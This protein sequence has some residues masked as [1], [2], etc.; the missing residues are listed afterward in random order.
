MGRRA[1]IPF[2]DLFDVTDRVASAL[3]QDIQD[4]IDRFA[5]VDHRARRSPGAVHHFGKLQS[6][7]EAVGT[8]TESIDIG[9]GTLALPLMHEGLPFQLSMARQAVAGNLEPAADA[10]QLNLFL[11]DFALTLDGLEPAIYVPEVGTTPRHLLRDPNNSTVRIIGSAVLRLQKTAGSSD[12]AAVFVDQPDPFDPGLPSGA[13]ARLT[14]SPPHFFLGSSDVGLTVRELEF[15]F[16]DDYSPPYVLEHNQGPSWVGLVIREATVYAPRNL[17]IVGD[18]SGGVRDLLIG[19]PMGIQGEFELQFGRTALDPATFIFRQEPDGA[20]RAVSGTGPA[21]TVDIAGGQD[22]STTIHAALN[23]PAPPDDG[24]LPTGA[25]QDWTARWIWPGQIPVEADTS[26]GT[27]RH[28]QTLTV[29]PVEIVTV[30]GEAT[31]FNHPPMTF[32][33]VA[34]GETPSMSA[35][36]G[37]ESF[38]NVVHLG[39]VAADIGAVTLAASSTAPGTSTFTWTIEAAQVE[40]TGASFSPRVDGLTGDHFVVLSED[41]DGED[42]A[43]ITRVRLRI[44]PDGELLVGCESGVFRSTDDTTPLDPAAVEATFDLSDFHA[45]GALNTKRE[46]AV[47]DPAA[48][49][50]VTVPADGLAQVTIATGDPSPPPEHDRHV[51]VLMRF[52]EDEVVGWGDHRPAQGRATANEADLQI[53]LLQWANNYPNAE[54]LA[55]GRCDDVGADVAGESPDTFNIGL[56]KDRAGKGRTLLTALGTG[57]TGDLIG[58]NRVFT[59]GETSLWDAGSEAGAALEGTAGLSAAEQSTAVGNVALAEGWLIKHEH[60]EHVDWVNNPSSGDAFQSIRERYRRID[61]HAVG[62]DAPL[63]GAIIRTGEPERDPVLRRSLVPS[64]DRTPAAVEPAT[65]GIDYRVKLVIRWDSP[66]ATEWADAVPTLAE[67]EFAWS[68]TETPLPELETGSGTT[69]VPVSTGAREVL[70]VYAKWIHDARTGFTRTTLG[71]RSDGD[72]D[73]LASTEQKNLT[74]ALAVGPMLLSGVDVDDDVVGSGARIAALVVAASFATVD[75]GGG[76]LVGDGSKT[77]LVAVEAEAQTRS[78]AD[79]TEDYQI[80]L[81]VEYVTTVHVNGGVLGIKTKADKPMKIRYKDVGIEYDSS[82]EGWEQFGLA[83]DTSS[84]EIEDGGQ[85]EIDGV[86]GDL[87]RIVE[88]SVGRGSLW[89]EGRIAIALNLG[90]V[91]ISEAIIRLVFGDGDPDPRFELRGFVLKADIPG[92]LEGEGR[93]HIEDGGII[94]AGVDASIVP[95]GLGANAALALGKPPEID[96]D[97]FLSLFLGVQ[98]S[99]PLP[100][101]QSG[102]AIYG[103]KGLFVMNGTRALPANPDPVGRELDWWQTAPELKYAPER[104]QY[105]IGVGVVVGTMPDVSFCFSAA[106]MVVVAFPD[107]EVIL[108]VDVKIIEVPDTTITDEGSP[109][110]AIT[111]L[112]VIDDEAVTVAVSAQ[113]EIPK[114]LSVKVPFG[115]YFPYTGNGVFVR[116]GSDGQTAHGR[117]GEPVT[118]TLLPGTLDA[119]VWAYLMIEQDGLPSLGGKPEFSFDGFSVGFGAGWGID[120]SAG[121]IKLS[122]SAEVLVGF[123]TNPLMIKGGVFV[124]GELDLVVTSIAARGELVLTYL[125]GN[126]FLDGQFCGE[127]DLFLFSISGCVG[128]HIGGDPND[129]DPPPPEVPVASISLTDRRDRIMG[130][131]R[132]GTGTP[133]GAPIFEV[134]DDGSNEG[135][136]IDDNNTVWPDTAPVLHFRHYVDAGDVSGQFEPGPAPSQPKWFGGNRL[137][138]AYRIDT[139]VLSKVSDPAHD[140]GDDLQSVWMTSPYRQPDSTVVDNPAPSEHEGS[141]L[142]LLDWNPWNWVLNMDDGGESTAGDPADQVSDLCDPLPVP[143]PACVFG[144]AATAAG[145]YAVWLRQDPPAPP[146]YPSRYAVIGEPAHR[147]ASDRI[148]GRDLQLLLAATGSSILPGRVVRLPFPVP[149]SSRTVTEGYLLP[150]ARRATDEGLVAASL[151]WEGLFDREVNDPT[152]TLLVC[153]VGARGGTERCVDFTGVAPGPELHRLEYEH[154]LITAAGQDGFELSDEVALGQPDRAGR[155]GIA[156]IAYP[157]SGIRVTSERICRRI[158][159][160]FM[161]FTMTASRVEAFD[162]AGAVVDTAVVTG[163]ERRPIVVSLEADQGIA[164]FTVVGGGFESVLYRICCDDLHVLPPSDDCEDFRELRPS[165]KAFERVEHNGIRFEPGEDGASLLLVDEVDQRGVTPA[166]GS[167]GG[168]EIRFPS[169]GMSIRLPRGCQEVEL[170]IMRFHSEPV[171]AVGLNAD[172]KAVAAAQSPR[173]GQGPIKLTL[174]PASPDERIKSISVEGGGSEAVVFR[175]CCVGDS[176]PA[177]TCIDFD[178]A[179]VDDKGVPSFTHEGTTF[180]D[181]RGQPGLRVQDIVDAG[182]RPHRP[183]TDGRRDLRF[184]DAG[185]RLELAQPCDEIIV[186]LMLFAGP[187]KAVAIDRLG[188]RVDIEA[189]TDEQRVEQVLTLRGPDIVAVELVGG[190]NEVAVYEICCRPADETPPVERGRPGT[191]VRGLGSTLLDPVVA[192]DRTA[193]DVTSSAADAVVVQGID[194]GEIV[195]IWPG[196]VLHTDDDQSCAV[197]EYE[198]PRDLP[199]PWDGFQIVSPLGKQVVL[200][201]VC[202]IDQRALDS[203]E[204]DEDARDDLVDDV[205]DVIDTPADERREI[206]L[207]RGEDYRIEVTWSWQAW[208]SNEDG[209]DTPP[210]TPPD[211]WTAGGTQV[212]S[213]AVADEDLDTGTTRDGLNEYVFDPRDVSR[214]LLR[215]EPPDGRAVHFTDDP[216]WAHFD[217]G[218]VEELLSVYGRELQIEIRRSDPPPQSTEA[219]LE[220]ALA[221][222]AGAFTWL[223]GPSAL[224]SL[225]YQRINEAV[226]DTPCLPD[227]PVV[228]GASLMGEFDLEPSAMYDFELVAPRTS[229]TDR[230]VVHATRFT[231]SRY[232]GPRGLVA[233]LGYGLDGTTAPYGPDDIILDPA[234]VLPTGS[235]MEVSDGLLGDLLR[236]IDADTLPLPTRRSVTY[237]VWRQAGADWQIE[238]VLVDSLETLH[239]DGAVQSGAGSELVTRLSLDAAEID[240]RTMSVFRVNETWTRVF[241]RPDSG[242]FTLT[243]GRHELLLRFG[244]SDGD[245]VGSRT[246]GHR[247]AVMDREGF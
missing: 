180:T 160:H 50:N 143:R 104:G 117:F 56:A 138:Y 48:P 25:L 235:T 154:L 229:G 156:E 109:E 71:V 202:G 239:R 207:E 65:S 15:D 210:A 173:L 67:A 233:D 13:V 198:P 243:D 150:L 80:K 224:Q 119:K 115:A 59:R 181:R 40:E 223:R 34:A 4:F 33:F 57:S 102:A 124:A 206:V 55:I 133:A 230:V 135:A 66:T 26:S 179:P 215:V 94:R 58:D 5:V 188:T 72:P 24:S 157:S 125:D 226:L 23:A 141:N 227:G 22:E 84:M 30:D 244:A 170:W 75:L 129:I 106:G 177:E 208:Q 31:P 164:G 69:P 222:L 137:K 189:T 136:S 17:P 147:T 236:L 73:G 87:L 9:I 38:D 167:D 163:P 8:D 97:I 39:G 165:D 159:L 196:R 70:T 41:V 123:G 88:V 16:A 216:V 89:M 183:G 98:F 142:K 148:T 111:G 112:I 134:T 140:F 6:V 191:R 131:A 161:R 214:Y 245:L 225:G 44:V 242:P 118:V 52:E 152:V 20:T 193:R 145:L 78:L 42:G 171:R 209:T 176:R 155:D 96:P 158:T 21:R 14:F 114:V 231:T 211:D 234:A 53:Q 83:Y 184:G 121:P 28:G 192:A 217:I 46:Q 195:E 47:L 95:L 166:R 3:P 205:T 247:P 92:V 86:L 175:I 238:G 168:A 199:G 182:R 218:H 203:R 45:Q 213:F 153:D 127:V 237:V 29:E 151:P 107:I 240:G 76:P 201:S 128:V 169:S 130:T 221:P 120:W 178:D 132:P 19:Q 12:V 144:L 110:G 79:P 7:V 186:R 51:Q 35:T 162:A 74:A 54:F 232:A 174:E 2:V 185:L 100:L 99:T 82:K 103:F 108:G 68:P 10:W 64:G 149:L 139:I 187:V 91:E 194:G 105:A 246:I 212:F 228:G 90:V 27:V 122:A 93:L 61:I 43:R 85:W 37:T 32:R 63:D 113:Y 116:L 204:E 49:A 172:G 190:D 101:A 18:L 126:V 11:T 1:G 197:I 241:L 219:A 81:T 36:V 146:P 200:L 77:T 62:G 220:A 60:P